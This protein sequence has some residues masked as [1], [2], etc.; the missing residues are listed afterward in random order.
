MEGRQLDAETRVIT[1]WEVSIKVV[2]GLLLPELNLSERKAVGGWGW[3]VWT[4]RL[5][6]GELPLSIPDAN[7]ERTQSPHS[8]QKEPTSGPSSDTAPQGSQ[9]SLSPW[10]QEEAQKP[11]TPWKTL[12]ARGS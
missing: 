6:P 7:D 10:G 1:D 9:S 5:L 8:L 3:G 2:R 11:A 12:L 4:D